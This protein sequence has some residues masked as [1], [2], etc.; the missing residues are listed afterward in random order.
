M[1]SSFHSPKDE[2][3]SG[4]HLDHV[5]ALAVYLAGGGRTYN[6]K[7]SR[8]SLGRTCGTDA[9][10]RLRNVGENTSTSTAAAAE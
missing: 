1:N 10:V 3:Y 4:E 7:D 5:T 2:P 6:W 8:N 9:F